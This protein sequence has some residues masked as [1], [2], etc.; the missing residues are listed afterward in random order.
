M[1][2]FARTLRMLALAALVAVPL[3][4]SEETAVNGPLDFTMK[5]IDGTEKPLADYKGNVVMIVNT[6]SKCGLTPQYEALEALHEK[7]ADKGLRILGFPAN[8]FMGQEPGTNDEIKFFCQSKYDVKFD[9]FSKISVKGDDIDPLYAWLTGEDTNKGF[10]GDINWNFEKF[11][12]GRDGKVAAR[13]SPKTKPD[14]PE[15]IEAIESALEA[16]VEA[17]AQQ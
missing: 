10:D 14:A 6:A 1:K 5:T 16:S 11:I 7:Y 9:M 2:T 17:P 4:G 8:N 12:I 3:A 13:F 15:V